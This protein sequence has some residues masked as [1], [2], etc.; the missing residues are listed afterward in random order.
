MGVNSGFMIAQVT[1]AALASENKAL[2]HPSSVDICRHQPTK[3]TMSR[4][5]AC[6]GSSSL[7]EMAKN[8]TGILAIEWLSACQGMDFRE[9]LKSS[10]N[11]E[12]ARKH[13]VTKWLTDK[14]RCLPRY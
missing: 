11:L 8:V 1:A 3:K 9:G 5:G 2:A 10:E 6:R 14:D 7:W 12:K 4:C 13:Y